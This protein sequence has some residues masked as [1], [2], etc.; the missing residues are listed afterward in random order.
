ML[1]A[2][3]TKP[4]TAYDV[5]NDL[6]KGKEFDIPEQYAWLDKDGHSRKSNKTKWW[7]DLRANVYEKW[8]FNCPPE[9]K[10]LE[11]DSGSKPYVYPADA[12]PVFFGHYWMEDEYPVIQEKNIVCLDYSIANE[13]SLVGYRWSGEQELNAKN[14]ESVGYRE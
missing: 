9:M 5:I 7:V 6:L 12:P 8:L 11:I 2:S 14:F 13:G 4:S 3:H 1:I 10:A